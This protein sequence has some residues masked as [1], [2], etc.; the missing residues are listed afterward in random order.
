MFAKRFLARESCLKP[1]VHTL[2][3]LLRRVSSRM[4]QFNCQS[5]PKRDSSC[6]GTSNFESAELDAEFIFILVT[7]DSTRLRRVNGRN[8]LVVFSSSTSFL[9]TNQFNCQNLRKR[10]CRPNNRL[11]CGVALQN[12]KFH[13]ASKIKNPS[14]Y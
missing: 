11:C 1:G 10:A 12:L 9:R 5:L 13:I 6:E 7:A 3:I 14:R 4:N 2:A 8:Q